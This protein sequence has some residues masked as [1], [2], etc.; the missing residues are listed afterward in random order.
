MLC[1]SANSSFLVSRKFCLCWLSELGI[2]HIYLLYNNVC[3]GSEWTMLMHESSQV[4]EFVWFLILPGTELRDV[5]WV[6]ICHLTI[7]F[8]VNTARG[9]PYNPTTNLFLHEFQKNNNCHQ[10][11]F[12]SHVYV[13]LILNK[14]GTITHTQNNDVAA[15]IFGR[16]NHHWRETALKT[17]KIM[18]Y[19]WKTVICQGWSSN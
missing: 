1:G 3:Y 5:S 12:T 19:I 2:H 13:F 8:F 11:N 16:T 6:H 4:W 7:S 15:T 9:I 10:N 18:P 17:I 14:E